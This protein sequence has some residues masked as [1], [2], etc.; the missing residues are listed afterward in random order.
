MSKNSN[1]ESVSC[2]HLIYSEGE[3]YLFLYF[4]K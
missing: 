1:A 3:V 4:D 2:I